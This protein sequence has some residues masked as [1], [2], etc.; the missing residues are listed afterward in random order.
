MGLMTG[1]YPWRT[2]FN[3]RRQPIIAENQ[4]TIASFLKSRGYRTSMVGKWHLGFTEK[5]IED[6]TRRV[7]RRPRGS[8]L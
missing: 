8:W 2:E 1:R 3:W 5:L 4:D 6:Y 7:A